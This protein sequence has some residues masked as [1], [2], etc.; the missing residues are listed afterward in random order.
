MKI[1]MEYN[2]DFIYFETNHHSLIEFLK[3]YVSKGWWAIEIPKRI[4]EYDTAA[5]RQLTY[6]WSTSKMIVPW[7]AVTKI[8]KC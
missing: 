7:H 2:D 3:D 5:P 4:E 8:E 6:K 1:R